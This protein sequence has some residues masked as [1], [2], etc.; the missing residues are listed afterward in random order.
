MSLITAYY[1][2]EV[3]AQD[4]RILNGIKSP[5]RLDCIA[6]Y[7]PT[8]HG[9]LPLFQNKRGM[10]FLYQAEARHMVRADSRRRASTALTNGDMN[11]SSLHFE[12]PEHGNTYCYGHPNGHDTLKD[13]RSNPTFPYRQDALLFVCDWQARTIEILVCQHG[14]PQLDNL[15]SLLLDGELDEEI[16]ELR[17]L[18]GPY[19]PY[20]RP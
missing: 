6:A 2:F 17:E 1:K 15:Y 12:Q 7:N 9:L 5:N 3:L 10:L 16:R 20:K 18:A 8:G 13:G 4:V 11:L 19:F 14:K